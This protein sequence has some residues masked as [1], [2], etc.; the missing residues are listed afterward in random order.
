MD[1]MQDC[2]EVLKNTT[3]DT[4]SEPFF[5][6]ILQHLLF[7]RDDVTVKP[8]YFKIIEECVSQI[9][10]HR[11][12]LDPDF[13]KNH[14][15]L[16]LGPVLDELR[17]KP[18]TN[19][20]NPKIEDL[21]KQL[22]EAISEKTE[23]AAK[24]AMVKEGGAAVGDGKLDPALMEKMKNA[25]IPGAPPPPPMPG[26][27]TILIILMVL[28]IFTFSQAIKFSVEFKFIIFIN[29]LSNFCAKFC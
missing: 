27:T 8:A 29:F 17:E 24:L 11:S 16:D 28:K 22:E 10:L 20:D 2:F 12:G 18:I 3:L 26:N 6:S 4:P 23:L 5:L 19:A 1:D 25:P 7:I 9:V 13:K 15:E 14:V 21:R